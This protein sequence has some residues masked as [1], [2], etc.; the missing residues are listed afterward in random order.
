MRCWQIGR[1]LVATFL[2]LRHPQQLLLI[3]L[4]IYNG[5]EQSAFAAEVSQVIISY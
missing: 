5:L 3:P 1:N 4:T 2:H